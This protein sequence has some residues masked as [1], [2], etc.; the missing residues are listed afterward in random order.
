MEAYQKTLLSVFLWLS[1]AFLVLPV[2]IYCVR[3]LIYLGAGCLLER[4]KD[5]ELPGCFRRL[6]KKL[7][8]KPSNRLG[9][10][11]TLAFSAWLLGSVWCLRYAVGYFAIKF[12][13]FS[14]LFED[15][16][17]GDLNAVEE[18]FNSVV[19][20]LQTFS[21]DEDYT[22]YVVAGKAMVGE[23][24][25]QNA[26]LQNVFG[27]Y[28][29]VM[30][31]VAPVAGGALIFE[32][33]SSI[34]PKIILNISYLKWWRQ[35][36]FFS[37]LN[38]A[39]LALAASIRED[40]TSLLR[41]PVL[42]FTDAYVDDEE[43]KSSE[44]LLEA[45]ML[46]AICVRD[47]LAHVKKNRHGGRKFFLID[48]L[49][50]GNLQTLAT[51]TN[52]HNE[53]YLR[54]AEIY[55]FTNDDAYIQVEK[56]IRD[57]LVADWHL[58]GEENEEL[59]TIIP[60]KSYRNLISGLL[61]ELP[62][63]EPLIGKT[64]NEKGRKDL[65]VTILGTGSIG[66]EMF[67]STYWFGQILDCD[68]KI[69]VLSQ[70]PEKRFWDKIDYVNPEI[71][72]T[73]N[74][75]DPILQINRKGD[76]SDPYCQ[77]D[78]RVCDVRSSAFLQ[79][80]GEGAR[81]ILD[82][83]YFL[84]ALGSDEDNIS[85]ANTIRSY[86]GEHHVAVADRAMKNGKPKA[87]PGRAVISY[88]V[89]DS[90]LSDALN[91]KKQFRYV[92]ESVDVYM[93]AIGNLQEVYSVGNVFM[94]EHMEKAEK[95]QSAYLSVQAGKDRAAVHRKRT[96]DDYKHW[97]NLARAM[98]AKYVMY[99]MGLQ[100]ISL[101]DYADKTDPAYRAAINSA[102]KKYEQIILGEAVLQNA[103]DKQVDRTLLHR[104][105]WM[106]HRRWSAFTRVKGLRYTDAYDVYATA[107]NIGSYKNMD[108]GL[109]PCLV[110]CDKK[111]IRLGTDGDGF[112]SLD[113]LYFVAKPEERDLLDDLSC[114][115]HEK[116]FNDY[117]FKLY[118]Y[119]FDFNNMKLPEEYEKYARQMAEIIHRQWFDAHKAA[120]WR[121][122]KERDNAAKVAP[123]MVPYE[124]LPVERKDDYLYM[125]TGR[126]KLALA[127]GYR[128]REEEPAKQ[129]A[130]EPVGV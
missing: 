128:I 18:I 49:E 97:A 20:A 7:A 82:T 5:M 75:K 40:K 87:A 53:E 36:Y 90:E 21:M 4:L 81:S 94:H 112:M 74:P 98:H 119:P 59:P 99:A 130:E 55:L 9:I 62:L 22:A 50:G 93:K 120:G 88:V 31:A 79:Y 8:R 28:A 27:I 56:R 41:K 110:E 89:Y 86:V 71:R 70:E 117:D 126:L 116:E 12:P 46:G 85:V 84:V 102:E 105:A 3:L 52:S 58:A 6:L 95:V 121:Y 100:E 106:E 17:F 61:V 45:K 124:D 44:R 54:K 29:A 64:E 26:C 92:N 101:L 19:H 114:D 35:K 42:I 66:T 76:M 63:F 1:V 30:N 125:A 127:L 32:I 39:S 38:E 77:V 60:V 107:G 47:D 129:K 2:V 118:D 24:T 11:K 103:E 68:L 23:L 73:M 25:G 123:E 15:L 80:L 69:N 13:G 113:N 83:D 33:L 96:K 78:Y 67:L 65:T 111:G 122:G 115:L 104:L 51:L 34:F 72:R 109:H 43:E 37:E 48:R 91:R 57:K 14:E 10:S 16:P 108:L